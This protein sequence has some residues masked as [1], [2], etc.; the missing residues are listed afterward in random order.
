MNRIG[1]AVLGGGCLGYLGYLGASAKWSDRAVT[2]S[3]LNSSSISIRPVPSLLRDRLQGVISIPCSL[4]ITGCPPGMVPRYY[5]NASSN[6]PDSNL[7]AT[8]N[9]IYLRS[10]YIGDDASMVRAVEKALNIK[11]AP[12]FIER[13]LPPTKEDRLRELLN[14]I[15]REA[16]SYGRTVL[17]IDNVRLPPEASPAID[18]FRA[19]VSGCSKG[20]HRISVVV[21]DIR[22]KSDFAHLHSTRLDV[23]TL[24]KDVAMEY[25]TSSLIY[26][27]LTD[28]T[29]AKEVIDL[30]GCGLIE[31][32]QICAISDLNEER[33]KT[34]LNLVYRQTVDNVKYHLR[35]IHRDHDVDWPPMEILLRQLASESEVRVKPYL[36]SS[37]DVLLEY[38]IIIEDLRSRC[39]MVR[40]SSVPAADAIKEFVKERL[41]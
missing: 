22:D 26:A 31:L 30:L 41:H 36:A 9:V 3:G 2:T 12:G 11:Y 39:V 5:A 33:L 18:M 24:P 21:A 20:N 38:D 23:R 14:R 29:S 6:I 19:W 16:M 25:V 4:E 40:P 13:L 1:Y 35:Y 34:E 37:V 7:P 32:E 8:A 28:G 17:L 10:T 27:G 15:E